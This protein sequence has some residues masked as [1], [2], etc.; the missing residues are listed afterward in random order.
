[1]DYFAFDIWAPGWATV[2]LSDGQQAL[3]VRVTN[4]A[5][6]D[7]IDDTISACLALLKG[8]PQATV[9]YFDEPGE[10]RLRIAR[11][12]ETL[13]LSVIWFPDDTPFTPRNEWFHDNQ[14]WVW[15]GNESPWPT[16]T[17]V[18]KATVPMAA[19][20]ADVHSSLHRCYGQ[21]GSEGY[22]WKWSEDDPLERLLELKR[23]LLTIS[24][25]P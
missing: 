11:S 21:L 5:H 14:T 15:V 22:R 12:N 13:H 1:M 4:F 18:F 16:C 8:A 25:P 7:P 3:K 19:F 24:D 6:N 20:L 10:R 9:S 23:L 17:E 2:S